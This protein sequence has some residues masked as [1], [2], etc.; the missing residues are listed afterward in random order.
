MPDL[1]KKIEH[2]EVLIEIENVFAFIHF[3]SMSAYKKIEHSEILTELKK[4]FRN[5]PFE[6][7]VRL[8]KSTVKF[9]PKL[10]TVS[11]LSI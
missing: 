7:H 2:S 3:S 1:K 6:F 4:T 10:K 11:R 5:Y 9:L 8:K